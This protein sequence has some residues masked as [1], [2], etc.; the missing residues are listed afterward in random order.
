MRARSRGRRNLRLDNGPVG[1]IAK[2]QIRRIFDPVLSLHPCPA[3]E[4]HVADARDR[5]TADILLG[6]DDDHRSACFAVQR[7]PQAGPWHRQRL[8]LPLGP[9]SLESATPVKRLLR[10]E[11]KRCLQAEEL[12]AKRH[13][14]PKASQI[15]KAW[16]A[17]GRTRLRSTRAGI[18]DI[19]LAV[20]AGR[21]LS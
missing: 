5:V 13:R 12:A 9:I 16:S 14:R 19:F 20:P 21:E 1:K 17:N 4:R 15:R 6:F 2:Q 7:W 11:P 18:L 8:R 10:S 3:A